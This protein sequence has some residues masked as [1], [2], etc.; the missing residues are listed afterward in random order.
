MHPADD[1]IRDLHVYTKP[2]A[3]ELDDGEAVI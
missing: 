1:G 2:A 3:L